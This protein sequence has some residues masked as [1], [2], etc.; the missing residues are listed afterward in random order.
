MKRLALFALVFALIAPAA[1]AQTATSFTGKWVGTITMTSPDGT[2]MTR[3]AEINLT[4]KGNVLTGTAGPPGQ[5][6]AIEKGEVKAGVGTWQITQPNGGLVKFTVK[7]VKDRLQGEFTQ[8]RNGTP[9]TVKI[10]TA[11]AKPAK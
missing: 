5:Q 6:T 3:D 8:D 11:R 4:Q 10:D 9:M 1:Y 2:P 7:I